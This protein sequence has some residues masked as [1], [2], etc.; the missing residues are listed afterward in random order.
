M[1]VIMTMWVMG[2][3]E[4]IEQ[5]AGENPEQMRSIS[6]RAVENGLIGHRFY[7]S[8]GQIMVIDEWPD[9]QS[10][11]RF[12]DSVQ[13]E[14]GEL[15]QRAGIEAEPQIRFWRKLDT[16]TEVGWGA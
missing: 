1:S 10:F 14:F 15:M 7:G 16:H 2:D 9:E 12:F 8:D 5:I 4:R 11:R 6:D 3:P 13:T